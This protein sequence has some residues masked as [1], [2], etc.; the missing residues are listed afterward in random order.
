MLL[1]QQHQH[2][3]LVS[4]HTWFERDLN[5]LAPDTTDLLLNGSHCKDDACALVQPTCRH[6]KGVTLLKWHA[7]AGGH[8][9][10]EQVVSVD[11]VA[12]AIADQ[13]MHA[14]R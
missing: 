1:L 10:V 13:G 2:L 11:I 3:L 7:W 6:C 9:L 14:D 4:K 8:K 5:T 12:S